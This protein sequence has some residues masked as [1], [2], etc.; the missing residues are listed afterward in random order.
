MVGFPGVGH[1]YEVVL[2]FGAQ[3]T[4]SSGEKKRGAAKDFDTGYHIA[5]DVWNELDARFGGRGLTHVYF[6][7]KQLPAVSTKECPTV[8]KE[9]PNG[10]GYFWANDKWKT[11]YQEAVREANVFVIFITHQWLESENCFEELD[12]FLKNSNWHNTRSGTSR[13]RKKHIVFVVA[14]SEAWND[15]RCDQVSTALK[16]SIN[17]EQ[18]GFTQVKMYYDWAHEKIKMYDAIMSSCDI[19]AVTGQ[20]TNAIAKAKTS[21][22]E[23]EDAN[24]EALLTKKMGGMSMSDPHPDFGGTLE[25]AAN[26]AK[27]VESLIKTFPKEWAWFCSID[28]NGDELVD[29][30]ELENA[31]AKNTG[32]D[33]AKAKTLFKFMDLDRNGKVDFGEFV[34][35]CRLGQVEVPDVMRGR[36]L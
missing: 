2:S 35:G 29:L 12:M 33:R 28:K 7:S 31:Y 5:I 16:G 26:F 25:S 13:S 3:E 27:Q 4:F 24:Q 19:H 21:S 9:R 23:L 6:D 15:P 14:T 36:K 30:V 1:R 11:Y 22:A 32:M 10:P 17:G 20:E 34:R 8:L 18:C